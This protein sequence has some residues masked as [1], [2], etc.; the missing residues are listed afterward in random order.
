MATTPVPTDIE[1]LDEMQL[2]GLECVWCAALLH[3]ETRVHVGYLLVLERRRLYACPECG[4]TKRLPTWPEY[5][6]A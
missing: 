1:R 3:S 4:T 2:S 5:G 6:S